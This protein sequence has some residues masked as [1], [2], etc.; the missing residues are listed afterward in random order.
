VFLRAKSE[1]VNVNTFIRVSG[2]GLVRLDPREVRSFTLREAVLAVKLELSGDDRVLSPTMHV[3]RG[4]REDEGAGIRDT[5]VFVV[6]R[7]CS[8][9]VANIGATHVGLVVGVG[10]T[11]PVSSEIFT[12]IDVNSTGVIEKTLGINVGTRILSNGSGATESMDSIRKSIN[13]IS[14]VKGL[15]TEDLE[16]ESITSQGRAVINVLI[17][18][19]N[20]DELLN[21][22]VKVELDLVTRRTNRL[23]T[24]E[25]ELSDQVLMGVLGHSAALI[26]VQKDIV[27]VQRGSY[28]RL[29]VGNGGRDRASNGVLSTRT[30]RLILAVQGGN[31]PQA[32]INRSNIKVDLDFVVLE[33]NKG[34]GKTRVGT[35]PE[36]KR[37]IKGSLR[38]S[39]TGSA[40][41]TRSQGVT[42]GLDIR[43]RRISDEGKLSGVTNHLE[44]S[45]LLL[46]S[47]GEL[48]PD[49]HPVTILT[50]DSLTTNL[51]LNLSNKLLTGVV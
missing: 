30:V 34:K 13:G 8:H 19:D 31:S 23:I 43:E 15:S 27:N 11:V 1:R 16:E 21:G 32:L 7:N 40:N 4:L 29:I 22:V 41:L 48:I 17:R 26:S 38:K 2:V 25:L 47:H 49:V 36:L 46:S 50:V 35:E 12:E 9:S 10:R 45:T 5:R 14:V 28:Q 42:R 6:I 51:D 44:V 33:S 20:P 3:K 18:L 24:S 37:N 39:V